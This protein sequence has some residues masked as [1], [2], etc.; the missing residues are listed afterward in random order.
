MPPGVHSATNP[1]GPP[2]HSA[3][4][5]IRPDSPTTSGAIPRPPDP[6]ARTQRPPST[7]GAAHTAT[8]HRS[9]Q[10][11]AAS[12]PPTWSHAPAIVVVER[13]VV[14]GLRARRSVEPDR[15]AAEAG[16]TGT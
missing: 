12:A 1:T 11:S 2:A 4:N 3:T 14:L 5:A 9:S 7:A 15:V 10:G 8:G 6:S 13:T 16:G